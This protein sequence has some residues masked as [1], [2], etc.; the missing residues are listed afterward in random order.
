MIIEAGGI[1]LST[2]LPF[3]WVDT[4]VMIEIFTFGDI[5]HAKRNE[6]DEKVEQRRLF[7]QGSLWM[8]TLFAEGGAFTQSYSHEWLEI[9]QKHC[10][11]GSDLREWAKITAFLFNEGDLFRGWEQNMVSGDKPRG[12]AA[13][14]FMVEHCKRTGMKL[15]SR[16][17]GARKRA[18]AVGVDAFLP[19]EWAE[20]FLPRSLAE[21]YF[22]PRLEA[23]LKRY[24]DGCPPE[25]RDACAKTV[26]S[27]RALYQ[28]IWK[29][30][31][32]AELFSA[33]S[34]FR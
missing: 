5:M 21:R 11:P 30:A 33:E 10:P 6:G 17:A 8:A 20:P 28:Y 3:A 14:I 13:D 24:S 18:R 25:H 1:R 26:Q 7:M 9:A 31:G 23:A 2:K 19:E 16:D 34:L 32:P 12:T 4:N 27:V 22:M 29:P 15:F